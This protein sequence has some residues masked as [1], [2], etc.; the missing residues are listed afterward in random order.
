MG[1]GLVSAVLLAAASPEARYFDRQVAPLL[2]RRCLGCHNNDLKNGDISFEDR[3]SLLKGGS[4]GPAVIPGDPAKS[5][6]IDALRHE[7]QLQMPPGPQ[8]PA[9]EIKV[10]T[11]WVRR[12]A[13]WGTKLRRPPN[14]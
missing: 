4:R 9:K 2:T 8:L 12:G 11:E 13:I 1:W 10:L 5:V 7:G 6:L 14:H 3:A